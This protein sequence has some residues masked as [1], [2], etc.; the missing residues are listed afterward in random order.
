MAESG[1][2]AVEHGRQSVA[3]HDKGAGSGRKFFAHRGIGKQHVE[4]AGQGTGIFLRDDQRGIAVARDLGNRARVRGDARNT[5]EHR[6]QQSLRD[7]F[8]RIG[9]QCKDIKRAEPRRN[10]VLLSG[11]DDP[12]AQRECVDLCVERCTLRPVA[13]RWTSSL[14]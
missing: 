14:P 7:T 4:A 3:R 13:S 11:E 9:R 10:V 1:L 8:V 12:V 5:R 6:L 2:H